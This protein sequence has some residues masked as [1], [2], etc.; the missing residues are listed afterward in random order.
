MIVFSNARVIVKWLDFLRVKSPDVFLF[1]Y[2]YPSL[3]TLGLYAAI[4]LC[5]DYVIIN[6]SHFI[7]SINSFIG[8]LVGFYIASLA[9]VSSFPG[10]NLDAI[11]KGRTPTLSFKRSGKMISEPLSRRRFLALVFGYLSVLSIIIYLMGFFRSNVY[12]DFEAIHWASDV[13][14]ILQW[15]FWLLYSWLC[16][17]LVVVTLLS[18]HYLIDRIHRE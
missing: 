12:I 5:R 14:E 1:Q 15:P 9:A 11:M 2:I 13:N 8:I 6:Q 16:F 10:E 18:V 3:A 17:S 4:L 7:E